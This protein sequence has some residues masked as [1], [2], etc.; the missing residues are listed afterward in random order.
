M[1]RILD[2]QISTPRLVG[3]IFVA[4]VLAGID[5][6]VFYVLISPKDTF[7]E[8]ILP[9]SFYSTV[10]TTLSSFVNPSLPTI[11]IMIAA[12]IFL[13]HFF[14]GTRIS[15][16]FF[17]VTGALFSWYTYTFFQ[18]GTIRIDIP[19]GL[20]Q[21]ISGT[22]SAHAVLLMWLF[23]APSLLTIVKGAIMLY[24]SN[25]KQERRVQSALDSV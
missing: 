7:L 25:R 13:D 24:S 16:A 3:R 15:G 8:R 19:S 18:G 17:I 5:F 2:L 1:P 12:L 23:I 4:T 20:V 14:R 22:L 11:G 6:F 21:G 9:T 10:H